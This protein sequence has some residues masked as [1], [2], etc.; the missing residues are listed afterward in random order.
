V[1]DYIWLWASTR[2]GGRS[3]A[4]IARNEV[5]TTAGIT[6][7]IAILFI[8]IIAMAGL[9]IVVV[10]ALAES[11]WAT[12][13]IAMT[14][15]LALFMGLYM[16]KWRA[17][18]VQEA[19]I[20]GVTVMFLAV[21]FGKN[22]AESSYAHFFLLTKH[23]IT[24]AM[25]LYTVAA[26]VLPVWLLLTPRAYLSTFMKIGTI[27]FLVLGV[28][29]LNPKLEA[30]AFSSFIGGG[31]PVVP[32]PLFPFVFI[33]IACGAISGF[34]ALV[35]TGTTSKMVDREWDIRPI[36]YGAMLIEGVVGVVAIITAC[37]LHPADYYAISTTPEVFQKLGMTVV[38]L[39]ELQS[40][41][42]ETVAGRPG[43]AVALAVGMAQIFSG[44]P[45][46]RGLMAYWY[47]FAIMFE[48]LFILTTIDSGTRI[49]RFLVQ[50]F[51]G[52]VWKPLARTDW[53]P[54]SLISTFVIVGRMDVFHLDRE[55]RDDLADVRRRQPAAG[56]RGAGGG[57]DDHRQ[58]RAQAVRLGHVPAALLH[59]HHDSD[60]GIH[61]RAGQ[62]LAD[63]HRSQPRLAHARLRAVDL[64][65]DHA[66]LR[67]DHPVRHGAALPASPGG[68]AI[69]TFE[70]TEAVIKRPI[71]PSSV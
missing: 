57:D 62:L 41:V 3:L 51:G 22:V 34:H 20:L 4:D 39:P 59:Q 65:R 7:A 5:S 9:G 36:G 45:G 43:G 55:H 40:E 61:E 16:F 44:L 71:T 37:A 2:R 25:A 27:A 19:T 64:H 63:G 35:S 10:N 21:V 60:G 69:P 68:G 56:R 38:N 31:G 8:L 14:V 54:G 1:Q 29:I 58:H 18:H 48:A 49:G 13:T 53:L 32:G 26:S 30:P 15:P 11:A 47:H 52:R 17:G 12:F 46:M 28:M 33:T 24:I 42:G 70:P 23:Q 6:A 66:R 50:E 67:G